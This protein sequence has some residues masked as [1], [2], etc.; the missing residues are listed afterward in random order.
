VDRV[1]QTPGRIG[2]RASGPAQLPGRLAK[3]YVGSSRGFMDT[4]LHKKRKAKVVEK[5]VG[6]HSTRSTGHV[7]RPAGRHLLR[8]R[9]GQVGGA[10]SRPYKYPPPVEIRTNTPLHGNSTCI[11]LSGEWRG[12]EGCRAS[13]P[14]RSPPCSS[15]A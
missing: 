1:G 8:Y 12:S 10:P 4:Y 3:S 5:G 14:I 15:S 11:A 9:I 2:P 13:W 7:A 6:S